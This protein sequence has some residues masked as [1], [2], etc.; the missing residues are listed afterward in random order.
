MARRFKIGSLSEKDLNTLDS[1]SRLYPGNL[2]DFIESNGRLPDEII[3]YFRNDTSP[4]ARTVEAKLQE[5]INK[6]PSSQQ[7]YQKYIDSSSDEAGL[8]DSELQDRLYAFG[9]LEKIPGTKRRVLDTNALASSIFDEMSKGQRFANDDALR[10]GAKYA[11][12]AFSRGDYNPQT[13]A[14]IIKDRAPE[15]NPSRFEALKSFGNAIGSSYGGAVQQGYY[16]KDIQDQSLDFSSD[17]KRLNELISSRQEKSN[18][19]Q[20]VTDYLTSLPEELA[21]NREDV[22]SNEQERALGRYSESVVP[23]TLQNLNSRGVLFSGDTEDLLTAEA[24]NL[25]NELNSFRQELE[26]QDNDFYFNAAYQNKIRQLL[27]SNVNLQESLNYERNNVLTEQ[28]RRFQASQ[29]DLNRRLDE[30]LYENDAQR[31]LRLNETQL[32]LQK[33]AQ[34]K[35]NK[36]ALYGQIGRIGGAIIGTAVT[37]GNP[38]GTAVG[39]EVGGTAGTVSAPSRIGG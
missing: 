31:R 5:V 9:E 6:L 32:K 4:G 14:E 2:L 8:T 17:K 37:G 19:E 27:E 30:K 38:A 20:Q 18:A 15:I 22:L 25:D 36:N 28:S 16:F 3:N 21:K 26:Q 10:A 34:D 33:D 39:A 12:E 35:A 1:V 11:A 7:A 23:S 29:S 13:F 24:L